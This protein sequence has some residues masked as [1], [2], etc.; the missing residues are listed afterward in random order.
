MHANLHKPGFSFQCNLCDKEFKLKKYLNRHLE[1]H[2]KH[3][4]RFAGNSMGDESSLGI[5]SYLQVGI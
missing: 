2:R 5:D 1:T 3:P 4:E